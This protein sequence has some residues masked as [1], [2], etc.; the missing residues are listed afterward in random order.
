V[1]MKLSRKFLIVIAVAALIG[2]PTLAG[3][4]DQPRYFKLTILHT[5]DVHGH[6]FPFD[7]GKEKNV[8][9]VARRGSLIRSLRA[10]ADWP[11]LV[12]D[13]GDIFTRGPLARIYRGE[14]DVAAMNVIPYDVI[15]LGNNEFKGADGLEGQRVMRER[16]RQARFPVVCANVVETATGKPLVPPYVILSAGGRRI[17]I[18]GLTAPRVAS[19]SQ[20]EGL[21]IRDPVDTAKDIVPQLLQQAD[22][23][24]ALTHI[25]YDLDRKLAA[26]VPG[27]DLIVGGDSH[28]WLFKPV[29]VPIV[30]SPQAF[31]VGGPVIVQDGE[32]G[33]CLGRVDLY[34]RRAT[35]HD[36]Q[37]MS[38]RG[39]LLPI[40]SPITDLPEVTRT[41]E[42]YIRPLREVVG[43]LEQEV[44][45]EKASA[46]TAEALRSVLGADVGAFSDSN[47]EA[48]LRAGPVTKLDL[49]KVYPFNNRVVSVRLTGRQLAEL[50]AQTKPGT[51]GAENLEPGKRYTFVAND[52]LLS[53][54][55]PAQGLDKETLEKRVY[56][57][58]IQYLCEKRRGS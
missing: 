44:P 48:G 34:M 14:P 31:W 43:R 6:L 39:K 22:V 2:V 52:S 55:P 8:G 1:A 47:I 36:Y 28:T 42:P 12:V 50:I 3:A 5:N 46:W 58:V 53:I 51:A 10:E 11:M 57:I 17:G 35:G 33:K 18:F 4:D 20:A 24:V 15:T 21:T 27:I 9:G 54:W 40:T 37:V 32:W 7:Y 49:L 30:D 45:K 29:V 19:Y 25:G 16:I 23:V 13:A 41:L 38:F 56:E 26:K